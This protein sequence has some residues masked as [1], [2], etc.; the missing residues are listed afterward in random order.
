MEKQATLNEN[1]KDNV[2]SKIQKGKEKVGKQVAEKLKPNSE[3]P[4]ANK[5]SQISSLKK[6]GLKA[7][8]AGFVVLAL[9]KPSIVESIF[10]AFD[11]SGRKKDRTETREIKF[12]K[13]VKKSKIKKFK[14][15]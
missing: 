15:L 1:I 5:I 6:L 9:I 4:V 14:F 12:P 13:E 11:F 2:S 10:N 7:F 3:V 8:G